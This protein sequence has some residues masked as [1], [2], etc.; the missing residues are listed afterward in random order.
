MGH[1]FG[2]QFSSRRLKQLGPQDRIV[3]QA[4]YC[5][6]IALA[7]ARKRSARS[8]MGEAAKFFGESKSRRMRKLARHSLG[9]GGSRNTNLRRATAWQE[10]QRQEIFG[11][12]ISA[13]LAEP[14][15]VC[16]ARFFLPATDR[17]ASIEF[18][19]RAPRLVPTLSGSRRRVIPRLCAESSNLTSDPWKLNHKQNIG[20]D[21][22]VRTIQEPTVLRRVA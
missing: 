7:S 20:L 3:K 18:R 6:E 10:R 9:G 15:Q 22:H 14:N 21:L 12:C 19:R 2:R 1:R 17:W 13:A 4:W 11:R 8:W 5:Y 16:E